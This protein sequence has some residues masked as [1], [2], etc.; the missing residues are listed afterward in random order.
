MEHRT[1]RH[2]PDGA[3]AVAEAAPSAAR[4]DRTP[5]GGAARLRALHPM[6]AALLGDAPFGT[7]SLQYARWIRSE[8][9]G[10][11]S[12]SRSFAAFL[13]RLPCLPRSDLPDLAALEWARA[14]VALEPPPI[15]VGRDALAGLSVGEFAASRLELVP[16]LRVLVLEHDVVRLWQRLRT[17]RSTEPPDPTPTVVVVWREGADVLHARLELDEALGLEAALAGDPIARV[18]AAFGRAEDPAG[19]A[20]A[21]LQSWFDEGWISAVAPPQPRDR[22]RR[23]RPVK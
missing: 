2:A 20:F 22:E 19:A 17:D 10:D 3:G 9:D 4:P 6:T 14:E 8:D 15:A 12:E 5:R 7:V 11:S 18:C 21:A 13:R 1:R 16:A 23:S